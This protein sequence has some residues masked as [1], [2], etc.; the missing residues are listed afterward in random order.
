MSEGGRIPMYVWVSRWKKKTK[1]ENASESDR[2]SQG[3]EKAACIELQ[4]LGS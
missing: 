2:I 1:G 4:P 3:R